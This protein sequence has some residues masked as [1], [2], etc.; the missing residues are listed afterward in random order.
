MLFYLLFFIIFSLKRNFLQKKK[1]ISSKKKNTFSQ[2]LFWIHFF[3]SVKN[4][5][6]NYNYCYFALQTSWT[7]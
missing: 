1:C 3:A 2:K 5:I 6:L 7:N 4:I